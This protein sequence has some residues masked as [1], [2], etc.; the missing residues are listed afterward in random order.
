LDVPSADMNDETF[1]VTLVTSLDPNMEV[2]FKIDL[3]VG[4]NTQW[5]FLKYVQ[6][7]LF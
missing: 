3:R 1:T 4:S 6:Y 5:D 7:Y 2:P